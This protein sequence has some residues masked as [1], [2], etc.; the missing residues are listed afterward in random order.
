VYVNCQKIIAFKLF[1]SGNRPAEV[2]NMLP[3]KKPTLFRYFQEW[4]RKK[5]IAEQAAEHNRLRECLKQ[6]IHSCEMDID[7]IRRYPEHHSKEELAK[8]QRWKARAAY[9]LKNPSLATAEE[10]KMLYK[11]YSYSG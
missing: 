1:D 9:L 3:L 5:R 11:L 6:R 8:L 7:Q 4:K 10:K 2:S